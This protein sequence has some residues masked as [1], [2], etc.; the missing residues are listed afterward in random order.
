M[1]EGFKEKE[2]G[3]GGRKGSGDS[4]KGLSQAGA[5]ASAKLPSVALWS[6]QAQRK[7]VAAEKVGVNV[8]IENKDTREQLVS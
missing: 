3:S 6:Q 7:E 5:V 2:V 8:K 1:G 4:R